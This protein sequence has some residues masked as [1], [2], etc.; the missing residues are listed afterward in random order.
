MRVSTSA[1]LLHT[2]ARV[3]SDR[4]GVVV[5]LLTSLRVSASVNPVR[6]AILISARR[7]NTPSSYRRRPFCRAGSGRMAIRS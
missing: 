7:W 4:R 1:S 6:W 3:C 5:M 2:M